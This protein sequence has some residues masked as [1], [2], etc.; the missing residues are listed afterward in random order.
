M[1]A[2]TGNGKHEFFWQDGY[3][4]GDYDLGGTR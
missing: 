1:S 3:R 4:F 2:Q